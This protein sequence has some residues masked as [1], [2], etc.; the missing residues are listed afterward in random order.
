M[1][2]KNMPRPKKNSNDE[3]DKKDKLR[4]GLSKLFVVKKAKSSA[5]NTKKP[6]STQNKK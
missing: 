3:N 4:F 1:F 6:K 2:I 5:G